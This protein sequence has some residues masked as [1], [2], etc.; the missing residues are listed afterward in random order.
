MV[1]LLYL[2]HVFHES[3]GDV[4]QRW[5]ETPTWQCFFWHRAQANLCQR[6]PSLGLQGV[7]V[8]C[9]ANDNFRWL[10]RMIVKKGHDLLLCLLQEGGLTGLFEK[11]A[12]VFGLNGQ[13]NPD[14]RWALA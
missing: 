5:G 9:A 14:Q 8:L 6:R 4:I 12:A 2:K 3:D 7:A 10:L 1:A 11:L 13:H